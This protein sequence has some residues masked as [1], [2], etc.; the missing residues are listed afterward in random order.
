MLVPRPCLI[1]TMQAFA[2]SIR[3]VLAGKHDDAHLSDPRC[4]AA[5]MLE[6]ELRGPAM[7]HE[8]KSI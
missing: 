1:S 4:T 6:T 5:D 8:W 2:E 3:L 7:P